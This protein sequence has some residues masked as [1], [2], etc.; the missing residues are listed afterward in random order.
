MELCAVNIRRSLEIRRNGGEF[1]SKLHCLMLDGVYRLTDGAPVFQAVPAP[2]PEQLQTLLTRI[3]QRVLRVLTRKGALIEQAPETPY[4]AD[5]D[6]DPA[7][8][9]ARLR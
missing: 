1:R 3:I 4:L 7:L 2:T 6:R 5:T 8:H 9:L